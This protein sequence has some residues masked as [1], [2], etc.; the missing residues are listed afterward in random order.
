[1]G[2]LLIARA[3]ERTAIYAIQ[4][5]T[6]SSVHAAPG[7]KIYLDATGIIIIII[8]TTNRT[9]HKKDDLICHIIKWFDFVN[10]FNKLKHIL[11]PLEIRHKG[12]IASV[13]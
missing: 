13:P 1:M 2:I 9:L 7:I 12:S 6:T 5:G 4:G 3:A 11:P 10:S 8:S